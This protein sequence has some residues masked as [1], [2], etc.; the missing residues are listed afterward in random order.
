MRVS[1]LSAQAQADHWVKSN[2][3]KTTTDSCGIKWELK[4][5]LA[6][7]SDSK[8]RWSC[9]IRP[10]ARLTVGELIDTATLHRSK[11]GRL[12]KILGNKTQ[13]SLS[14]KIRKLQDI[15]Q[16][17]LRRRVKFELVDLKREIARNSFEQLKL[18]A[19]YR[20]ADQLLNFNV[21]LI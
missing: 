11:D 15:S 3:I 4:I 20:K 9:E 12:I 18:A 13:L 14:L 21:S 16:I 6:D 5:T 19:V 2:A 1:Q 7:Q 10:T 17:A 8:G